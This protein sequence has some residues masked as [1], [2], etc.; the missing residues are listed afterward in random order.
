MPSGEPVKGLGEIE[1]SHHACAELTTKNQ[2]ILFATLSKKEPSTSRG[3][4]RALGFDFAADN[5]Y[6]EKPLDDQEDQDAK[7]RGKFVGQGG[8]R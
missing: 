5:L 2:V 1:R 7:E 6:T 3:E 4:T 8:K